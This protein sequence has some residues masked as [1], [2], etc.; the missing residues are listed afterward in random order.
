[1]AKSVDAAD[2]KIGVPAGK[3]A[4][5]TAQ[6][7]GTL[8]GNTLSQSRAEAPSGEGVETGR[9]APKAFGQWRRDSPDHERHQT[10]AKVEVVRKS[11]S[12]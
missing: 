8:T 6:S 10:A 4:G 2:F 1:M 3:S 5:R 9:A 12:L 11:A 7:R